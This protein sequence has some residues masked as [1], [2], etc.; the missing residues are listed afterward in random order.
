MR[1]WRPV[2]GWARAL[3][4]AALLL[5]LL[6][7]AASLYSKKDDVE[8]L[9]AKNFDGARREGRL[10]RRLGFRALTLAARRPRRACA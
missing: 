7:P 6:R 10:R 1:S 5:A 3:L 4:H 9:T 8:L 2:G